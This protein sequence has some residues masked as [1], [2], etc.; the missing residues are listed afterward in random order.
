ML[1]VRMVLTNVGSKNGSYQ[2][3]GSTG[4]GVWS[5]GGSGEGWP[6]RRSSRR[7]PEDEC[8]RKCCCLSVQ[9]EGNLLFIEYTKEIRGSLKNSMI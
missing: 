5:G 2:C 6:A 4:A 3:W 7:G 8:T 1:V 9:P